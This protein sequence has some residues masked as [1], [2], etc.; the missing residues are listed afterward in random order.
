M[1]EEVTLRQQLEAALAAVE[2]EARS[3]A[4]AWDHTC[5]IWQAS[6][7]PSLLRKMQALA[8]N[9]SS[10]DRRSE[11]LSEILRSKVLFRRD[12]KIAVQA[13]SLEIRSSAAN[14]ACQQW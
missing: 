1:P 5:G 3:A 13:A 6:K 8:Q 9:T 4:E 7:H 10:L 14:R 2:R 11:D 12:V